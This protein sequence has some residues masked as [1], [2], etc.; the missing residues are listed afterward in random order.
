LEIFV[1]AVFYKRG[2]TPWF[3]RVTMTRVSANDMRSINDSAANDARSANDSE[4]LMTR[5]AQMTA[6]RAMTR[7]LV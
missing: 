4:A 7:T 6:K 5:A 1:I 3:F 2:T